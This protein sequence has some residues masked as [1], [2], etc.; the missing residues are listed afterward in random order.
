MTIIRNQPAVESNGKPVTVP[1]RP[2]GRDLADQAVNLRVYIAVQ[3][4]QKC[5]AAGLESDQYSSGAVTATCISLEKQGIRGISD[6]VFSSV[7]QSSE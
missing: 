6:E 1:Q 4:R 2:K 7:V 3:L 5:L